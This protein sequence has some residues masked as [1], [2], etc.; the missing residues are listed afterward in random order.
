[1][2]CFSRRDQ[3]MKYFQIIMLLSIASLLASAGCSK[4]ESRRKVPHKK[5][6]LSTKPHPDDGCGSH[7]VRFKC[8]GKCYPVLKQGPCRNI[9]DWVTVDP[10]TLLVI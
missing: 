2:T 8:D 7:S 9:H 1:M 4:I 6:S 5:K 10:E 3:E